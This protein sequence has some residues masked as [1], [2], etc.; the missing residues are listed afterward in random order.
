MDV[1]F[2]HGIYIPELDLWLDPHRTKASAFVSHAHSD[3]TKQH[4]EVFATP[5]TAALMRG[6]GIL[7]A[8]F[9]EIHYGCPVEWRGGQV[10]FYPAGHVLGSAQTLV[11]HAGTRLL[12]SGDFKLRPGLSCERIEVPQADIVV[13][14]TT[15]GRPR[16]R[17]PDSAEVMRDIREWCAATL[18]DGACPILF[19]YSLGKGQ[20]VL[21]GLEGAD[22]PVYL[23]AAHWDMTRIYREMGINFIHHERH[24]AGT[25]LKGAL[26]CPGQCRRFKW[27]QRMC[28]DQPVRTAYISG[29]ALDSW[30]GHGTDVA[31]ALSDHADYPDLLEYVALTGAKRVF[32]MHGFESEFAGDLR[33]RGIEAR[34]LAQALGMKR[35]AQLSLF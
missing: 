1:H 32:T 29:W 3:H 26:L 6:R 7:R 2:D 22:F 34:P 10:T 15:F 18:A 33:N 5:A 19:C 12:Y 27:F 9:R 23:Q 8:K 13:M 20:E 14:E 21:A 25:P 28:A 4:G 24:A 30:R 11:E 17:F 31:F 16:Y 35:G